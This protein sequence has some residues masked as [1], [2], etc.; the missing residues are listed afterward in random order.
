VPALHVRNI[1]PDLHQRIRR[2][3]AADDASLSAEVVSLLDRA[4]RD[5]E[6]RG[7]Q[8]RVLAEIRRRRF[9]APR[10]AP[11]APALLREDRAR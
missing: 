11:G 10:G 2:L 6:M 9:K 5:R 4:L 7:R 8:K 3:A 1:P